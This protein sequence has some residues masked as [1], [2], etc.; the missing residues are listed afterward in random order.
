MTLRT[1]AVKQAAERLGIPVHQPV[2]IKKPPLSEWVTAQKVDVAVVMAY[3]RIL[4]QAV[5]DAPRRGCMN[6]HA[7]LLPRLRGAAPINW[8]IVRGEKETGISLMQMD[9]GMDTGPVLGSKK[10]FIEPEETAGQLADR[11]ALLAAEVVK[12]DIIPAV[13]GEFEPVIQADDEAT[14]A[15]MLS[16]RDG[17][18]DWNQSAEQIHALVRGMTPWPGAYSFLRGLTLKVHRC[19]LHKGESSDPPG[20]ILLADSSSVIVSCGRGLLSLET[21]Q[22][23]GKKPMQAGAMVVGRTIQQGDRLGLVASC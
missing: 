19:A 2:K 18:I 22:L 15:P 14:H 12:E 3:G 1:P 17:E 11:L 4:P 16:K 6:L 23:P 5:L 20:T 9:A 8:A 10:L 13:N 7:S 21:L